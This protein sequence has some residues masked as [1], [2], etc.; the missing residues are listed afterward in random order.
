M[1]RCQVHQETAFSSL[2]LQ[3]FFLRNFLPS[4]PHDLTG[5]GPV[6]ALLSSGGNITIRLSVMHFLPSHMWV[7]SAPPAQ[8]FWAREYFNAMGA[9]SSGAPL[10]FNIPDL[11]LLKYNSPQYSI[12]ITYAPVDLRSCYATDEAEDTALVYCLYTLADA[13]RSPLIRRIRVFHHVGFDR[14]VYNRQNPLCITQ[15]KFITACPGANP[16]LNTDNILYGVSVR[17]PVEF[18]QLRFR[19]LLATNYTRWPPALPMLLSALDVDG[20]GSVRIADS[21]IEVPDLAATVAGLRALPGG[22]GS[23]AAATTTATAE[24]DLQPRVDAWPTESQLTAPPATAAPVKGGG[25]AVG[26][27]AETGSSAAAAVGGGYIVGPWT[28]GN[29]ANSAAGT[30]TRTSAGF[31]ITSWNLTKGAWRRYVDRTATVDA[32]YGGSWAF[33][34]VRLEEADDAN[35][36]ALCFDAALEQGL[37]WRSQVATVAND[38]ELRAALARG[39]RYIQVV[40]DIRFNPTNWPSGSTALVLGSSTVE[41]RGCHP[42]PGR[43]YTLDLSGLVIVLRTSGR[44]LFEGDLRFTGVGWELLSPAA[45]VAVAAGLQDMGLLAAFAVAAGPAGSF[46]SVELDRVTVDATV[47]ARGSGLRPSD[48]YAVLHL[49]HI[50]PEVQA[51]NM[52]PYGASG[53]LLGVW[54]VTENSTQAG[55]WV[56]THTNVTWELA[57]DDGSSSRQRPV[58]AIALPVAVCGS[59]AVLALLSAAALYMYRRRRRGIGGPASADG[60]LPLVFKP[61]AGTGEGMPGADGAGPVFRHKSFSSSGGDPARGRLG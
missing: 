20:Q 45:V 55:W 25:S 2:V 42:V 6:P 27:S 39:A 17:A 1:R 32:S 41:V 5:L 59:L 13:L 51:L 36:R 57:L 24:L 31:R 43:R 48:M 11:Y 3:R 28:S 40:S 19:G 33:T 7:F 23:G 12:S 14:I 56:F 16:V 18:T 47:D 35:A 46:G 8:S 34:N 58:L 53:I 60:C 15:P 37:I 9:T 4:S 10:S 52:T 44:L 50:T 26:P 49:N 30:Q 21:T 54:S 29:D 61:S 38:V 22:S